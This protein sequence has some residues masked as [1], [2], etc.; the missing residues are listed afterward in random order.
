M[1][2]VPTYT[3]YNFNIMSKVYKIMF[4]SGV[5]EIILFLRHFILYIY[6]FGDFIMSLRVT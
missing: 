1:I 5:V 4:T 3:V 6:L 2:N